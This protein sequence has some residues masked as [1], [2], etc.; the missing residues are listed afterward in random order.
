MQQSFS[1][2]REHPMANPSFNIGLQLPTQPGAYTMPTPTYP[3]VP[4]Y[5]TTPGVNI[6][7]P[8]DTYTGLSN[9][10]MAEAIAVGGVAGYKAPRGLQG[11]RSELKI[12]KTGARSAA[13]RSYSSRGGNRYGSYRDD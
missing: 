3:T 10:N 7:V 2:W 5:P 9:T 1:C 8:T 11:V 13:G 4:G 12:T 6:G